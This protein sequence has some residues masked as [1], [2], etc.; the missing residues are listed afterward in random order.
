MLDLYRLS[1]KIFSSLIYNVYI[2]TSWF[3]Q[4]SVIVQSAKDVAL[5]QLLH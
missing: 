2:R 4:V 5:A 1:I 3:L